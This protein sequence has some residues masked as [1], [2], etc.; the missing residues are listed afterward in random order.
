MSEEEAER[1]E[2]A[3]AATGSEIRSSSSTNKHGSQSA[4]ATV[5][6]FTGLLGKDLWAVVNSDEADSETAV[7]DNEPAAETEYEALVRDLSECGD[8]PWWNTS[9]VP[10]ISLAGIEWTEETQG[11]DGSWETVH[12]VQGQLTGGEM[13]SVRSAAAPLLERAAAGQQ[14][15]NEYSALQAAIGVEREGNQTTACRVT[16]RGTAATGPVTHT[17]SVTFEPV[18]MS[19]AEARERLRLL[20][21][22]RDTEPSY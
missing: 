13:D 2:A 19:A 17:K 3:L 20:N 7:H 18:R 14:W 11:E 16:V 5:I 12:T 8:R 4:R 10:G 21:E 1:T 6:R 9:D 22:E 15:R